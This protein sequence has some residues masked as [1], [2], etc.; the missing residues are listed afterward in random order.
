MCVV[1]TQQENCFAR[2]GKIPW[3]HCYDVMQFLASWMIWS[4]T[5]E[6]GFFVVSWIDWGTIRKSRI[7]KKLRDAVCSQCKSHGPC[8][9]LSH[10]PPLELPGPWV[11]L[12][13]GLSGRYFWTIY[14]IYFLLSTLELSTGTGALQWGR[15]CSLMRTPGHSHSVMIARYGDLIIHFDFPVLFYKQTDFRAILYV[16]INV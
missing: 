2:H 3:D 5:L 16:A 8:D 1:L 11:Y 7:S 14:V 10:I 15:W 6:S 13:S 12:L 4:K 9:K